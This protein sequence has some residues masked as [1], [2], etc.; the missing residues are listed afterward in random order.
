M[1]RASVAYE[2]LA[3]ALWPAIGLSALYLT[4]AL[5]GLF[6]Y[7]PWVLQS[8]LLAA[9]ITAVTLALW[10]GFEVFAD[11]VR[12]FRDLGEKNLNRQPESLRLLNVPA[13]LE[14]LVR[15]AFQASQKRS[16][17]V[18]PRNPSFRCAALS[19]S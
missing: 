9:T 11:G 6:A 10:R 14:T 16:R 2:R 13:L 15:R 7:I 1:A 18:R 8:L 19:Y 3:P 4:A 12:P 17:A 5:L